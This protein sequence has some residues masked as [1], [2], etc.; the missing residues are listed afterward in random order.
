MALTTPMTTMPR[1]G[2]LVKIISP[3]AWTRPQS[4]YAPVERG[5]ERDLLKRVQYF[6]RLRQQRTT[7]SPEASP[8]PQAGGLGGGL[9]GAH[10]TR[11]P[12][13]T[14]APPSHDAPM[15]LALCCPRRRPWLGCFATSWGSAVAV[16]H[17]HP[18]GEHVLGSFAIGLAWVWPGRTKDLRPV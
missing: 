10:M 17:G 9:A 6:A 15:T 5:F 18:H 7:A 1:M 4:F 3:T 2:F 8:P 11:D 16:S 12:V 14:H 13:D